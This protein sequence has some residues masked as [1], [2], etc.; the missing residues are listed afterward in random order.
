MPKVYLSPSVQ[1]FNEFV[2]GGTEEQYM[3]LIADAIEPYLTASG[4]EFERNNPNES[5]SQAIANSNA[6]G[7]D[8]HVAIHSNAAPEA[9]AG[10][11]RGTDIY[12]N[13]NSYYGKQMADILEKDFEEISQTPDRVK[14]MPTTTLAELRRTINPAVLIETAYHDNID[15]EQ[16]IKEN[17]DLIG[18]TIAESIAEYFG[19]PFVSPMDGANDFVMEN[20][21]ALMETEIIEDNNRRDNQ[22]IE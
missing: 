12:Y 18:R 8:L 4:I 13:T 14:T 9:L 3:N 2:N 7:A 11:L 15:D 10:K 16:W 6:S 21:S 19:V 20:P 22:I 17:I 5:L 1:E